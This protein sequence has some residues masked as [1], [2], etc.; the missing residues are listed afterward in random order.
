MVYE[1]LSDHTDVSFQDEQFVIKDNRH[2]NPVYSLL[3]SIKPRLMVLDVF[4]LRTF[5]KLILKVPELAI[6]L[7]VF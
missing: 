1:L 5:R 4:R 2:M 6:P 3:D 7:V